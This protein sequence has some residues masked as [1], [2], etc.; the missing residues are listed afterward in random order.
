[1]AGSGRNIDVV[2]SALDVFDTEICHTAQRRDP[3][4]Y[5]RLM[6]GVN[7]CSQLPTTQIF[8]GRPSAEW[9]ALKMSNKCK[10]ICQK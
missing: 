5:F 7:D 3:F 6:L 10:M 9:L 1:M 8:R 4:D 2:A